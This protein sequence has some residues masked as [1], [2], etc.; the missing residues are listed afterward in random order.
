MKTVKDPG[1]GSKF[2]K[3]LKRLMNRDGSYNIIRRGGLTP[4]KDF[5]KYLMELKTYKFLI[6]TLLFYIAINIFFTCLYLMVGIDQLN[7]I[8]DHQNSFF[9]AFFFSTQTFTTVGYG[10]VSPGKIG[11]EI[12]AMVEALVGLLAFALVTGQLYGRFSRPNARLAFSKNVIITP[13]EEGKALMFKMVNRR[14]N[15]LLN[16]KVK[17]FLSLD[18]TEGED[19]FNKDYFQINLETDSITFFPLTWTLVHKINEDSPLFELTLDEIINKRAELFVLIETFD[20]TFSQEIVQK[21][22][23]GQG[24]WLENVKF[25]GNFRPNDDGKLELFV[26]EI[27][28]VTAI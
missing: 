14:N 11:A 26:D 7:G 9:S 4:I 12:I 27:D 6:F 23:Y 24:D 2:Q 20:E 3:P 18:K 15:I 22:S 17:L 5:Y 8:S 28:K 25:E 1:L 21:H 13:F 16:T 10:S 19:H